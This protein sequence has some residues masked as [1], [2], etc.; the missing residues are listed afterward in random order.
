MQL[1]SLSKSGGLSVRSGVAMPG[2][3]RDGVAFDFAF[4]LLDLGKLL[5]IE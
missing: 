5:A 3:L 2:H 4:F 1:S